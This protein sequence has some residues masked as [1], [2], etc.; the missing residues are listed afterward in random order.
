[1]IPTGVISLDTLR[2]EDLI[3]V[4]LDTL[5]ELNPERAAELREQGAD[6][7]AHLESGLEPNPDHLGWFMED[8]FDALDQNAP[9]GYFFGSAEGDGAC[10]GFWT[11]GPTDDAEDQE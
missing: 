9:Y 11:L 6:V 10:F 5:A 7:I 2:E 1:M 8:L 3:P 4:F